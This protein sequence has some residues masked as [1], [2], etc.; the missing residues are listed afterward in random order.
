MK[1][2][3]LRMSGVAAVSLVALLWAF[4]G[5]AAVAGSEQGQSQASHHRPTPDQIA[6]GQFA[7][8]A[9]QSRHHRKKHVRFG[10]IVDHDSTLGD[11]NF[12]FAKGHAD[13]KRGEQVVEGGIRE[14]NSDGLIPGLRWS[15]QSMGPIPSKRQYVVTA[16]SDLGGLGRKD[17]V[18]VAVCESGR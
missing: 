17:F 2:Q 1:A 9:S 13:C 4:P 15:L 3:Q 10:K 16:T 14:I 6:A 12:N 11:G 8:H 18:A 5:Q 7:P